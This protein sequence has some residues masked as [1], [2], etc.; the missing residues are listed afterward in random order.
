MA[1]RFFAEGT[2]FQLANPRKTSSWIKQ[3]IK[4]EKRKLSSL[5]YIFCSDDYLLELNTRFLKHRTLTDILTFDYSEDPSF[6]DGEIYI[7]I[8]RVKDNAD[9]FKRAFDEELHRVIIH[10]V[11]HLIG[12]KDKKA[13]DKA[14]MRKKEEACLSLR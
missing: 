5:I 3:T 9:E 4:K 7:S 1:I 13:S 6:I 8:D 12:Y 11:L 2:D 14:F 10:G